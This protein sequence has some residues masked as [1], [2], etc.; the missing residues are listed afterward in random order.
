MR[1]RCGLGIAI[2][3]LS[4]TV[5]TPRA[6]ASDDG[7]TKSSPTPVG[8]ESNGE[9]VAIVV[10]GPTGPVRTIRHD[11]PGRAGQWTCR[12]YAG[13]GH[14]QGFSA[15]GAGVVEPVAGQ[16][17]TLQCTDDSGAVV[18]QRDLTYDPADPLPGLDDPAQAAAEALAALELPTPAVAVNPPPPAAQLVGV[19]TW[20][21]I[22]NWTVRRATATL[23]GVSATVT[24]TPTQV[25]WTSDP[26]GSTVTCRGPGTPYD[27]SRPPDAQASTCTLLFE[28][29]GPRQVT[30]TVTYAVTWTASTGDAGILDALTRAA[31]VG[32]TVDQAQALIN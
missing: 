23:D 21:W 22:A 28:T 25:T 17:V 3:L 16:L 32:L 4:M 14:G 5:Q 11:G 29:A 15:T 9:P 6:L 8:T 10:M 30:A 20:L 2:V 19:A 26:D 13:G 7:S 12:Y 24:A 1:M 27:P 18:Y 31:T